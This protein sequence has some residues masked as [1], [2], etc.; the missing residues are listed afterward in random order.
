M[1]APKTANYTPSINRVACGGGSRGQK[2]DYKLLQ[3]T[4]V[5]QGAALPGINVK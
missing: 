1:S 5:N 3:K 2:V 4:L